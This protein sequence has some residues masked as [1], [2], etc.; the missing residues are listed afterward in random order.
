MVAGQ[1]LVFKGDEMPL[2]DSY[3]GEVVVLDAGFEQL[4]G[5]AVAD[6]YGGHVIDD[7]L[8]NL[9]VEGQAGG[10][11]GFYPGLFQQAVDFF[12][13]VPADILG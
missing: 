5:E 6:E 3:G 13:G 9:G 4:G 8:L 11:V 10:R 1:Q 12:V 2:G 7:H